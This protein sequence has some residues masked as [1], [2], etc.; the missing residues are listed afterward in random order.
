[1]VVV[2]VWLMRKRAY[3][4]RLPKAIMRQGLNATLSSDVFYTDDGVYP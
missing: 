3:R 1:V 2:G 4:S